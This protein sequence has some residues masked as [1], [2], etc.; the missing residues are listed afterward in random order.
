[1]IDLVMCEAIQATLQAELGT[2]VYVGL[3]HDNERI[4]FPCVLLDLRGSSLLKSPLWTGQLTA[5]VGH[6]ADDSTVEEHAELV[7]QVSTILNDLTIT[8]DAVQ[9]YGIVS[10]SSDNVNQERH[11]NT[12]LVYTMGY[13]PK[14]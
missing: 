8:S 14:P 7:A 5:A 9:L 2:G 4:T 11:W 1:M 3:P 13:G 10:K 12:N 6:Q